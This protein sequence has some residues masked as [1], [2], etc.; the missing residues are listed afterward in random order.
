MFFFSSSSLWRAQDIHLSGYRWRPV[1]LVGPNAYV[2][3]RCWLN[4]FLIYMSAPLG[5]FHF[6]H[7]P[8]HPKPHHIQQPLQMFSK[9]NGICSSLFYS[10]RMYTEMCKIS[11]YRII[12]GAPFFGYFLCVRIDI[13]HVFII[14]IIFIGLRRVI[15]FANL[16]GKVVL[17]GYQW[18]FLFTSNTYA[19]RW[20]HTI[21]RHGFSGQ[22]LNIY[23]KPPALHGALRCELTL[24]WLDGPVSRLS[25]A[26]PLVRR[27]DPFFSVCSGSFRMGRTEKRGG[28]STQLQNRGRRNLTVHALFSR[29][30]C[31]WVL[32][33][34]LVTLSPLLHQAVQETWLILCYFHGKGRSHKACCLRA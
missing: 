6:R 30:R 12:D 14:W 28:R 31:S 2:V 29:T 24:F 13:V 8:V 20:F 34:V 7:H 33:D 26:L 16:T 27:H 10:S 21:S 19:L 22:V 32:L 17:S 23:I 15:Y 5:R 9:H 3:L 1:F 11:V 18:G 4:P 25:C